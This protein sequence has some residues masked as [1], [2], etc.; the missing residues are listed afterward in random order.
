MVK[1]NDEYYFNT[2]FLNERLKL[3]LSQS[4]FG[5]KMFVSKQ[6]ISAVENNRLIPSGR[7]L[8]DFLNTFGYKVELK[9]TF[10]HSTSPSSSSLS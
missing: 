7:M 4:R 5:K 6:Y 2:L 3:G 1:V 10:V 9:K 8:I